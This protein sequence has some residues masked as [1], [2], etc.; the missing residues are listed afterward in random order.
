MRLTFK[1]TTEFIIRVAL[2]ISLMAYFSDVSNL[3]G[4]SEPLNKIALSLFLTYGSVTLSPL[5]YNKIVR[6]FKWVFVTPHV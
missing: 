5:I 4:V 3:H 1:N 6:L 2:A